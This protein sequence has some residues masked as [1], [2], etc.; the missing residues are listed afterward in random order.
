M[1]VSIKIERRKYEYFNRS[2]KRL[3]GILV[4][5]R[6]FPKKVNVSS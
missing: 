6:K 5:D 1:G 4:G 2:E 3:L